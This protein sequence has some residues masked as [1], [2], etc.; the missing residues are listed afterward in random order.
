[1]AVGVSPAA[2]AG[3]ALADATRT[4]PKPPKLPN[5]FRGKGTYIV[6]DMRQKVGFKWRARKGDVQMTAG[7]KSDAIYFTN[8]IDNDSLYTLTYKWPRSV[9][10]RA[11]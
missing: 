5:N 1:M 10:G 9:E 6:K 7:S 8:L 2:S 11:G 3:A 4:P